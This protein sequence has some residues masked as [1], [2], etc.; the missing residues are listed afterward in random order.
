MPPKTF[1]PTSSA[2]AAADREMLDAPAEPIVTEITESLRVALPDKYHGDR[3]QLSAFLLQLELYFKF[4]DDKFRTTDS[5]SL[6]ASSYLRGEAAKGIEPF[7]KDYFNNPDDD[8]DMVITRII[9]GSFNGFK[10][11]IRRVF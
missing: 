9:F 2:N 4:N 7:L 1:S 5:Y 11:E 8:G 6:W 10:S 3:K